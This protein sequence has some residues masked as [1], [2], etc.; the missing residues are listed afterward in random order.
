LGAEQLITDQHRN[1]FANDGLLV[2]KGFYNLEKDITPIQRGIHS[3]IGLLIRKYDLPIEQAEF[4]PE[5]FDSGYLQMVRLSRSYGSEVYDAVKQIPDFL[6]LICSERSQ[7]A[8]C[9]LRNV[10]LAGIGTASYGIRIDHPLE[11]KFRSQW[12]QEFLTQ[13]Q[14]IDGV[15]M[16][17]PLVPVKADM[18]PVIVCPGSHRDGLCK[19]RKS[20]KY[21]HKEGAYKIGL[22]DEDAVIARYQQVAPL[23]EPGDLILM[24]YLTLHQSGVNTSQR[25]RWSIQYRFFNFRDPTGIRLGWK[26]SVTIGT[27][28]EELF[29]EFF[30]KE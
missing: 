17:T 6:R 3:I 22:L 12:H 27:D 21:E 24:D 13:P 14:S 26:P 5:T 18:G 4:A 30:I 25:S 23:T 8:Y 16:W 15:V 19:Y 10:D 9:Q 28:I 2:I 1:D 29:S 11:D 7:T 20:G